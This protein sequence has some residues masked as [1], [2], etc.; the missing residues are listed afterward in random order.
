MIFETGY[1]ETVCK[2]GLANRLEEG[3]THCRTSGQI[4]H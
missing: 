3:G 4:T 2:D 1:R